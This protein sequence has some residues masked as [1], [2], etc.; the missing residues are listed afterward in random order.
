MNRRELLKYIAAITGTAVVGGEV[1]L[2]GCK[3][4][5]EEVS[6]NQ[7]M[8]SLMDEIG[9]TIIPTTDTPGAKAA[10][11]GEFMKV[12]VNDCYRPEEQKIFKEGLISVE[13]FSKQE[14]NESFLESTPTQRHSLLVKLEKEAKAYNDK[15]DLDDKIRKEQWEKSNNGIPWKDRKDFNPTPSHYYT[16]LK[17]LTLWGYF[18]SEIGMTKQLRHNPVPGRYDGEAEYR[19]EKAWAE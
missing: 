12:I 2:M 18:S 19:G 16:M 5:T 3:S 13:K 10:R 8:I 15:R 4:G 6:F 7:K 17:Q 9:E 14:N 1:F 11:V